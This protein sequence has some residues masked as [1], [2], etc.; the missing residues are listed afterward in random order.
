MYRLSKGTKN[1]GMDGYFPMLRFECVAFTTFDELL[2]WLVLVS[3][4]TSKCQVKKK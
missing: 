4:E 2:M 1:P 3:V